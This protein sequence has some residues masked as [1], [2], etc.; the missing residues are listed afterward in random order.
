MGIVVVVVVV[1]VIDGGGGEMCF[2]LRVLDWCCYSSTTKG[3]LS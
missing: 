2:L 1:V 3:D